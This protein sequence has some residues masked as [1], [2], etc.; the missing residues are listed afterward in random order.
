MVEELGEV[1]LTFAQEAD[2]WAVAESEVVAFHSAGRARQGSKGGAA[3]RDARGVDPSR[4]RALRML[5]EGKSR[6]EVAQALQITTRT[7]DRW[8]AA[9]SRK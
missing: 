5:A 6:V 2:R 9:K 1:L 7:L 3:T 4:A 8:R